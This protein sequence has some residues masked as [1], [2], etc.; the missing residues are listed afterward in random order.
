MKKCDLTHAMRRNMFCRSGYT[1]PPYCFLA[2][3]IAQRWAV[4]HHGSP[5]IA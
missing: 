2:I 4:P 3:H 1:L 5:I